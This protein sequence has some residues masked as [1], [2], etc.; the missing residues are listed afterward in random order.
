MQYAPTTAFHRSATYYLQNSQTINI[1]TKIIDR[2]P[3]KT[4]SVFAPFEGSVLKHLIIKNTK[5]GAKI[6]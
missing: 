2:S 4:L 3:I 6:I 5:I 1:F